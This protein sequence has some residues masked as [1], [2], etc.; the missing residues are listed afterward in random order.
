MA[1]DLSDWKTNPLSNAILDLMEDI[2]NEARELARRQF[3]WQGTDP[4]N[5]GSPPSPHVDELAAFSPQLASAV[6][7]SYVEYLRDGRGTPKRKALIK[8]HRKEVCRAA[9]ALYE[10][11]TREGISH[12]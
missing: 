1:E 7:V 2:G 12:V 9:V 5:P 3:Y 8:A 10:Y 4:E 11:R 6:V